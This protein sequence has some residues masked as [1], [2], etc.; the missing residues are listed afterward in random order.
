MANVNGRAD[1]HNNARPLLPSSF[2]ANFRPRCGSRATPAR[3][4]SR[5]DRHHRATPATRGAVGM[6]PLRPFPMATR[7]TAPATSACNSGRNANG[8]VEGAGLVRVSHP[9]HPLS[10]QQLPCVGKRYNRYGTHLL[11][12]MNDG[13]VCS[14]PLQ[15]TD[16]VAP[17]PEIV[18]GRHRALFCTRDMME[19]ARLVGELGRQRHRAKGRNV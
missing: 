11:L 15:W 5:W 17:D 18:R 7:R 1:N 16:L 9:F 13:A 14:I 12:Q 2:R 19:L 10:G 3:P 6:R 4:W 8:P